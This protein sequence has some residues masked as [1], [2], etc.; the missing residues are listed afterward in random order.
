MRCK[1][2][3]TKVKHSKLYGEEH[4]FDIVRYRECMSCGEEIRTVEIAIPSRLTLTGVVNKIKFWV[5]RL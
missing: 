3:H 4:D 1:H 5:G 2:T